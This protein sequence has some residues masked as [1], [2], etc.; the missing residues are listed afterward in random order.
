MAKKIEV[1]QSEPEIPTKILAESIVQI[2]ADM[3][4]LRASGLN[5]KAIVVLLKHSTGIPMVDIDKVIDA[6]AE[7]RA[8]YCS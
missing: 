2:S 6:L 1:E 5:R 7:L 4:K 8:T 3:K